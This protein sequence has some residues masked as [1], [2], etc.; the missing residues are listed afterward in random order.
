MKKMARVFYVISLT[1]V[2]LAS[3][4]ASSDRIGQ[5]TPQGEKRFYTLGCGDD[6]EI[7][8]RKREVTIYSAPLDWNDFVSAFTIKLVKN[9]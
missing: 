1:L 5:I 7:Q 4:G 8:M 9:Q 6:W 3:C 2:F